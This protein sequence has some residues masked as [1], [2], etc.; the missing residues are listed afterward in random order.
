MN[1]TLRLILAVIGGWIIGSLVNYGIITIGPSMIP[2]PEGID[3]ND[4]ESLKENVH[5]LTGKDYIM[6][7]IAHALGTLVGAFAAVKLALTQKFRAA[8]IVGV[9]FLL[10]GIAAAYMMFG[11]HFYTGLDFLLAYIPMALLGHRLAS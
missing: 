6:P 3:F 1:P 7:I 5:L 4:M 9:L 10:G 11:F 2:P 8:M